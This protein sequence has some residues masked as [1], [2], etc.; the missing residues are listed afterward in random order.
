M[1]FKEDYSKGQMLAWHG[2]RTSSNAFS[3]WTQLH[4]CIPGLPYLQK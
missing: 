3:Y 4:F 1:I 2:G